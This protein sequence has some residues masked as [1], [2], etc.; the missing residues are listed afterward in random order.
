MFSDYNIKISDSLMHK[1][2][3]IIDIMAEILN[4]PAGLIMRINNEDIEVFL[5]S[6]TEGNPYSP[7]DKEYLPGSG[8][9]CETVINTVNMLLVPNALKSETWKNNP[10]IKLNMISYLGFPISF[11]DNTVFGTICVLDNKENAYSDLYIDLI[12]KFRD[13]INTDLELIYVNRELGHE[14]QK[15]VDYAEEV[16]TLRGMIPICARCKKV[17][18]KDDRDWKNMLSY[19]KKHSEA[20]FSHFLCNDC[21]HELYG[22][23][24][25]F[26]QVKNQFPSD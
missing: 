19:I 3:N 1:W 12:R 20:H 23:Q 26:E 17:K 8:L 10:D 2:Q 9:Y 16:K 21:I 6:A 7:G 25:W 24:D 13:T 11:P 18:G 14:N 5:A 4:V 22:G 15:L